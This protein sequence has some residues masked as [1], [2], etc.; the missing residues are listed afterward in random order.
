M[1]AI[2]ARNVTK[3]F[4]DERILKDLNLTGIRVRSSASLAPAVRARVPL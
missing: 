3:S 1:A 4:G 2:E